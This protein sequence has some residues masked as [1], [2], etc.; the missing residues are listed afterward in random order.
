MFAMLLTCVASCALPSTP[1]P[2]PLGDQPTLPDLLSGLPEA[3]ET[4]TQPVLESVTKRSKASTQSL[5][6]G[7]QS[8]PRTTT[9]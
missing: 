7:A 5:S 2:T 4:V 8:P 6:S 3:G 9:P 1:K